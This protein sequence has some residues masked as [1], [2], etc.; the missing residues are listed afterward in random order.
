MHFLVYGADGATGLRVVDQALDKGHRVRASVVSLEALG[1]KARRHDC[2]EW[3]ESDVMRRDALDGDMKDVDAVIDA[4]GIAAS[5]STAVSPPPLYTKGTANI[6]AAMKDAGVDRLVTISATFVE[7]MA[8]GPIWFKMAAK[9]GLSA[10]FEEMAK[11]EKELRA[12]DGIRWTAA[13]PGWLLD[14]APSGDYRIFED[15]IPED[16]IRTRTGDLADF[17]IRCVE[18]DVHIRGTPAIARAEP[19]EKS[20][21]DAVLEDML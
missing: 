8:R 6:T 9:L 12:T 4:V 20:G 15:V 14:E 21:P 11:M 3:V 17:M 18:E 1:D 2:L 7:T 13:R 19:P 5:L 16:L 10:I